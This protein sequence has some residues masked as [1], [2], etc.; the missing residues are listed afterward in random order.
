MLNRRLRPAAPV[1]SPRPREGRVGALQEATVAAQRPHLW[2][3]ACLRLEGVADIDHRVVGKRRVGDHDAHLGLVF[4]SRRELR[5]S[6]SVDIVSFR[7]P[8]RP[9]SGH[10]VAHCGQY[11]PP[12]VRLF[13][14]NGPVGAVRCARRPEALHGRC[15]GNP[16]R[17][18]CIRHASASGGHQ[19]H[20]LQ[21]Q[22]HLLRAV[23][24]LHPFGVHDQFGGVGAS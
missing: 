18:A 10:S 2:R 15:A 7:S 24:D 9:T 16:V 5:R 22:E 12:S 14:R 19:P 20:A 23:I 8:Y 3:I 21:L 11:R 1:G 13:T 6:L 4:A 17:P